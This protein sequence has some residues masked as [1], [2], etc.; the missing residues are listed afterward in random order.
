MDKGLLSLLRDSVSWQLPGLSYGG[1]K[2][3]IQAL[4]LGLDGKFSVCLDREDLLL[5]CT[6]KACFVPGHSSGRAWSTCRFA[7][8]L[9]P[10]VK[11]GEGER[12]AN[13]SLFLD[14]N[15]DL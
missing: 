6:P 11:S 3:K 14:V 10:A 1:R 7:S 12:E 8:F 4:L 2:Y 15:N 13:S 9:T 5:F